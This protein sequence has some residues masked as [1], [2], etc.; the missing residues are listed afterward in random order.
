MANFLHSSGVAVIRELPGTKTK[1]SLGT[2]VHFSPGVLGAAKH[3]TLKPNKAI[4]FFIVNPFKIKLLRDF[5]N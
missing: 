5:Y 2:G 1:A 3:S 4:I